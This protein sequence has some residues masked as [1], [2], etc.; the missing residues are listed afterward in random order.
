MRRQRHA[1]GQRPVT[2]DPQTLF[3]LRTTTEQTPSGA[4]RSCKASIFILMA[5]FPGSNI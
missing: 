5:L 4:A 3:I 1:H 2:L